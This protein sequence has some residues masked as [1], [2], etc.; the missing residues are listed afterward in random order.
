MTRS[1][2][3]RDLTL[4]GLT[5]DALAAD[6]F[7]QFEE[8]LDEVERALDGNLA[9][10]ML[11]EFEV[12]A[13]A[14]EHGRFDEASIL[15]MVRH[16]IQHRPRFK[17]LLAGSHTLDEFQRWSGYLINVQVV[18]ISYLSQAETRQLVER[19]VD[20]FALRYEPAAAQRVCGADAGP[21]LPGAAFVRRNC[22]PEERAAPGGS[23]GWRGDD[24]AT[25]VP[26]TLQHGS[27]FF[28]D[29]EHNQVDA[30]GLAVLRLMATHPEAKRRPAPNWWPTC[31]ACWPW[32]RRCSNCSSANS[33]KPS[34]TAIASR[35]NWCGAGLRHGRED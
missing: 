28:A 30:V 19:P 26:D 13:D 3:Q 12:L 4:P 33:L 32:K 24:V 11:D 21:S 27:F 23:G 31:P 20:N 8:W 34:P 14:L 7:S 9:L 15:G 6:P 10:L 18:H 17:V 5:R 16:L 25:A 29:I 2:Q 22:G 1:A 35:W